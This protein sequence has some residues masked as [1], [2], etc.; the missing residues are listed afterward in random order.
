MNLEALTPEIQS[1]I[2]GILMLSALFAL[3]N[4][5]LTGFAIYN[6]SKAEK[7]NRAWL[8][9]IPIGNFYQ[10]I[11]LGKGNYFFIATLIGVMIFGSST[12]GISSILGLVFSIVYSGYSIYMYSK[13][14]DK[15]DVNIFLIAIGV[16]APIFILVESLGG[17]V[18][19]VLLIGM[20]G[21]FKLARN[22]KKPINKNERVIETRVIGRKKKKNK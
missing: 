8:A 16:L 4:Y 6:V 10:L 15:Y 3:V 17:L 1:A 11:K 9:W 20:Y 7:V 22:A 19:P 2:M 13:L 21:Q 18:I 12:N 14:C 5:I